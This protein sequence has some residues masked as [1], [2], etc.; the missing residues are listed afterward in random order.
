MR[1]A[2]SSI[3]AALLFTTF[4]LP[5]RA[6][7]APAAEGNA[8][9]KS[10]EELLNQ[11]MTAL[12]IADEGASAKEVMKVTHKS[13]WAKDGSDLSPDLRRFSFHK[14]HDN[15]KFY[16]S[17]VKITRVRETSMSGVGFKETAEAGSVVDYFVKKKEGVNGMPAPVKVFFPKGGGAPKILDMGSL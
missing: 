12:L 6:E 10:G 2:L 3:A 4:A 9:D 1:L 11:F 5:A 16:A 14:A 17:P 13:K 7:D 8:R 15:A